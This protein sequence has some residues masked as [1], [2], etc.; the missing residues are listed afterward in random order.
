[1]KRT[2]YKVI[3]TAGPIIVHSVGEA[4]Y[5]EIFYGFEY[6]EVEKEEEVAA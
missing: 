6:E 4:R 1:M 3:T 5:Y 2:V